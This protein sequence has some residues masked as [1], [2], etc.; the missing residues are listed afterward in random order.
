MKCPKAFTIFLLH[1]L[2]LSDFRNSSHFLAMSPLS[3]R[4]TILFDCL[5]MA[6][7]NKQRLFNFHEVQF[8]HLFLKICPI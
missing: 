2:F 3:E 1:W 5:I 7:F 4:E 8:V 6:F